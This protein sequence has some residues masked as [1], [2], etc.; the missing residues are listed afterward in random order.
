MHVT[1]LGSLSCQSFFPLVL[2]DISWLSMFATTKFFS[3]L[4]TQNIKNKFH[5]D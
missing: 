5:F 2:K 4:H 1:L 3:R